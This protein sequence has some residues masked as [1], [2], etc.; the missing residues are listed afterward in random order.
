[1]KGHIVSCFTN[2]CKLSMIINDVI[3]RLYSKQAHAGANAALEDIQA[4][5][6]AWREESP[7]HLRYAAEK[8]PSLCPPPHIVSQK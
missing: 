1:M 3:L 5:L 8:L 7:K 4:R 6:T 2:S